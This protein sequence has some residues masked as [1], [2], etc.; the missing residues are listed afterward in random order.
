MYF[1]RTLVDHEWG[2]EGGVDWLR[3]WAKEESGAVGG[4]STRSRAGGVLRNE[5]RAPK[6]SLSR[7]FGGLCEASALTAAQWGK[8]EAKD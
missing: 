2:D 3:I 1:P 4:C 5:F 6:A 8:H 7:T